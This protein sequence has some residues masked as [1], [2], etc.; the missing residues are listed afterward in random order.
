MGSESGSQSRIS[1]SLTNTTVIVQWGNAG[2]PSPSSITST[3]QESS[4]TVSQEAMHNDVIQTQ[5]DQ[6]RELDA[7]LAKINRDNY[8]LMGGTQG[9]NITRSKQSKYDTAKSN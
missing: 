4:F 9:K 8:Q 2:A 6:I 5:Q 7:M 1:S 3:T